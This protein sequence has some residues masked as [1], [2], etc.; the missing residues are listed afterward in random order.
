MN[1]HK[2]FAELARGIID[3][4]AQW[5]SEEQD[6]QIEKYLLRPIHIRGGVVKEE[7]ELKDAKQEKATE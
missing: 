6:Q 7:W 3:A 4:P 1:L 2:A 5:F